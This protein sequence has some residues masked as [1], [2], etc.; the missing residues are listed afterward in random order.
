MTLVNNA[1]VH[2]SKPSFQWCIFHLPMSFNFW[3]VLHAPR[4]HLYFVSTTSTNP[5][6]SIRFFILS[7][8][9]K[10]LPNRS[11]HSMASFPHSSHISPGLIEPS[12][13]L[14]TGDNSSC[15]IYPPGARCLLRRRG[16]LKIVRKPWSL[17][18]LIL[19]E[20]LVVE[21]WPVRNATVQEPNV[22]EVKVVFLVHPFAAAVVDLEA[23]IG[24]EEV[25]LNGWQISRW[26]LS[27]SY[28]FT[29]SIR[30]RVTYYLCLGKLVC[31]IP[32]RACCQNKTLLQE[33]PLPYI[34][35]MPVP[36]PIS[37]ARLGFTIGARKSLSLRV[38]RK[39][40]WL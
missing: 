29:W 38:R 8:I 26:R 10:V 18:G 27:T 12:S 34:A 33:I 32:S 21:G 19:L 22:Y 17:K 24:G 6:C 30:G 25:R 13:E 9:W 23:K 5:A 1:I 36:V 16:Q 2:P 31:E 15:S 14:G 28:L 40:W 4:G 7:I 11:P 37:R 39:I 35:Q 3:S 20:T